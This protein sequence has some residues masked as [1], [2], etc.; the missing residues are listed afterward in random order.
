MSKAPQIQKLPG[1]NHMPDV[2]LQ[3][4]PFFSWPPDPARMI[5]WI[6]A[7][8]MRIAE[9]TILIGVALITWAFFQPSLETTATLSFGWIA[10]LFLR[11]IILISLVGINATAVW[12]HRKLPISFVGQNHK[13]RKDTSL[14]ARTQDQT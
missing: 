9:N 7:R 8:W 5:R 11:N 12:I 10:G 2:P 6:A 3:V 13:Q 4:S 14:F 1:W